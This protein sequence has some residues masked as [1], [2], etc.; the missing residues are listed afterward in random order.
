MSD[1]S[2]I[3]VID[4]TP[5]PAEDCRAAAAVLAAW[6]AAGVPARARRL[7]AAR[8][9]DFPRGSREYVTADRRP[10]PNG[11]YWL[12]RATGGPWL[13]PA[14]EAAVEGPLVLAAASAED[15]PEGVD[16]VLRREDIPLVVDEWGRPWLS[17]PV[18]GL[19]EA[20]PQAAPAPRGPEVRVCVVGFD[21]HLRNIN[22]TV[23]ARL[24]DAA[25]AEGYRLIASTIPAGTVVAEGLPA[26]ID[27][28]VL[29]GG[30]DMGQV[31]ALVRGSQDAWEADLPL[32]GLCLG[33][34]GMTLAAMRR[35]GWPDAD[36]EEIV[37]T[38]NSRNGFVRMKDARGEDRDRKGDATLVPA[39]GSRLAA[40]L[41]GPV[42]VRMH[43]RFC[44]N[45]EGY[46]VA[47]SAGQLATAFDPLGVVDAVEFPGRRFQIGLQG[48]PEISVSP[49]LPGLWRGFLKACAEQAG[50]A[51]A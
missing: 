6:R 9:A 11:C 3:A 21:N 46:A 22:P 10:M 34:Q 24:A 41:A 47:T 12:E 51:R 19:P 25:D 49:G 40:L 1:R 29:P 37:G 14:T 30:G 2:V 38:A 28:L 13:P 31:E 48:H 36:L 33:M 4:P 50:I 17:G 15:L 27:G 44:M 8:D 42:E 20:I 5:V 18:P 45:P 43:H 16:L 35:G 23:I 39:P 32:L 7:P 26:G